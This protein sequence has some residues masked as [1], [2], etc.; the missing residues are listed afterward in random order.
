MWGPRALH[1]FSRRC[2]SSTWQMSGAFTGCSRDLSK[3]RCFCCLLAHAAP[4][5]LVTHR[6]QQQQQLGR[7][8]HNE[9][10][11]TEA[12]NISL[13][14]I[15]SPAAATAAA[16]AAAATAAAATA[17]AAAAAAAGGACS[18]FLPLRF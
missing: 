9:L 8:S 10:G 14:I 18:S 11:E 3:P 5:L 16:A 6:Q 7:G 2:S 1:A 17:A 12:T 13:T 4:Q 15:L